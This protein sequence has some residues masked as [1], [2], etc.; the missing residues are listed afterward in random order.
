MNEH[1]R[2]ALASLVEVAGAVLVAI[3]SMQPEERQR[4]RMQCWRGLAAGA[5]KVAERT[6]RLAIRA[7]H[8]YNRE[9]RGG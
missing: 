6:G 7:E 9:A 1:E 2:R 8:A 3:L 5:R 4:L